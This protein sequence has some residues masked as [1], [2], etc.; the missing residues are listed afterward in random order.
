MHLKRSRVPKTWPLVRKGKKY[1]V[2]PSHSLKSGIPLLIVLRDI[3]GLAETKKEVKKL[4]NLGKIKVNG[5]TVKQEN[6]SLMLF[7][8]LDLNDKKF[9]VVLEKKKFGVVEIESKEA[10]KKIAKVIG[11]KILREGRTQINLSDGRNFLTEE[12]VKVGDSVLIA[13]K[14]NKI[15]EI[16]EFKEKSK[17]MFL[18]G[19][20]IGKIG[21]VESIDEKRKIITL[22]VGEEKINTKLKNLMVIK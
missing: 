19:K 10:E 6:F 21:K 15:L 3:L 2:K 7:D 13:L 4:L 18:S 11:K 16:L 17:I 14:E 12:R 22:K 5:K 8:N 9:R 1:V 20:H